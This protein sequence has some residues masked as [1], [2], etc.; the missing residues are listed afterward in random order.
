[1]P[2][3]H[4]VNVDA[5]QQA[6]AEVRADLAKARRTQKIQGVWRFAQGQPQFSA[7]VSFEGGEVN[8]ESDQPS[9]Q[10]GGG[11]RPSPMQYA[12]FGLAACF[13]TTLVTTAALE[14][15][16]LNEVRT[17]AEFDINLAKSL[18]L[19]EEPIIE[20]VRL[21][22]EVRSP[23]PRQA[24]EALARLAEARC[25]ATYCLT[26]PIPLTSQVVALEPAAR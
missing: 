7:G 20:Q 9:F 18:G 13:T 1:M 17:T 2:W 12:L 25:P 8:L 5:L 4:N 3:I 21:T 24:I 16:A 10:G 26:N 11:R 6:I 14:G 19:S 15:I 22:I 23:A